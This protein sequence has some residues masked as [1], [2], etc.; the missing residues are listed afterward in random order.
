MIHTISPGFFCGPSVIEAIT[1]EDMLSVILP[2]LNRASRAEYLLDEV[3]ESRIPDMLHV[4]VELGY[5]VGE[6]KHNA[7]YLGDVGSWHNKF[8]DYVIMLFTM[9]HVLV[10][11]EG[12]AYDNHTPMGCP[13]LTHPFTKVK[14]VSA[15]IVRKM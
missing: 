8:F 5:R 1:G 3:I 13:A 2:A 14:V 10:V 11:H 9:E 12:M 6:Y 4:L 15:Y 7:A